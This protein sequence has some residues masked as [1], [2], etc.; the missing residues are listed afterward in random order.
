VV[1]S[2]AQSDSSPFGGLTSSY[3]SLL[4]V[5]SAQL[6]ALMHRW[7]YALAPLVNSISTRSRSSKLGAKVACVSS[8]VPPPNVPLP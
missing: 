6:T 3:S 7:P 2:V 1:F 8:L 4:S 5:I